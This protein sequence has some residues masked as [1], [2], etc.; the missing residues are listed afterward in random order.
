M[1]EQI[2]GFDLEYCRGFLGKCPYGLTEESRVW[3]DKVKKRL[4]LSSFK[5]LELAALKKHQFFKIGLSACPNSCAKSQIK[6]LGIIFKRKPFWDKEKCKLCLE[7]IE[8][9]PDKALSLEREQIIISQNCLDCGQCLKKCSFEG[10]G[11]ARAYVSVLLGGRL[12]R[13]PK[14]AEEIFKLTEKD[15][16]LFIDCLLGLLEQREKE[17]KQG[18]D[19]FRVYTYKEIKD[20][21]FR[22]LGN[23]P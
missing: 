13:H 7:C 20:A 19:L 21:F 18:K 16:L 1:Q 15:T 2:L 3:L 9:C 6:D 4:A 17:L 8:F 10:F 23:N 11:L 5:K 22:K 14:L 12:G